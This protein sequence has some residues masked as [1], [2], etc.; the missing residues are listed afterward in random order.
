MVS[1][2]K[3][4]WTSIRS[5]G[6]YSMAAGTLYA[7]SKTGGATSSLDS[8]VVKLY[9]RAPSISPMGGVYAFAQSVTLSTSLSGA[10]IFYTTDGTAPATSATGTTSKYS[11][12]IPILTT[13]SIKA[14][15]V[16]AGYVTSVV[17]SALYEIA[18]STTYG[19]PWKSGI[20]YGAIKDARDGQIYRTVK[21]GTQNWMAQNLNF[22]ADS[23]WCYSNNGVD[24]CGKYGRLY[25]WSAAMGASASYDETWLS[26]TPPTR[27]ICP[28][29]WHVPTNAEW[30]KLFNAVDSATSGPKLRSISGWY[31]N[32]GTDTYG[33]RI[34]PTGL[35]T[36]GT[37][38]LNIGQDAVHW[39]ASEPDMTHAG[40]SLSWYSDAAF[41]LGTSGPKI[42]GYALRCI[43]N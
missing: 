1:T 4:S 10:D 23:S 2:N 5:G 32:T 15:A 21:I 25:R 34:L 43:G 38:I 39:T 18:D 9:Q 22:K 17:A 19:I 6:T 36:F 26:P 29:G 14:I 37:L 28:S 33:F 8:I 20:T 7:F 31:E 3:A 16:K 11:G 27:G 30:I 40:Y 13:K 41:G 35:R 42:D 24:S 12:A